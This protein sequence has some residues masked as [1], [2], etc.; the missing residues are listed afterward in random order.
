M[1]DLNALYPF[2]EG[3]GRIQRIFINQLAK[4]AGYKLD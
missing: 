4:N 1:A 3:S 2:R